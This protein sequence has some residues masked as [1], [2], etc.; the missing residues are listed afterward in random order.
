MAD[1]NLMEKITHA[2]KFRVFAWSNLL[3][4]VIVY[5]ESGSGSHEGR[6]CSKTFE[7]DAPAA[8]R[9]SCSASF[10]QKNR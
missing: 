10:V 7:P 6:A 9:A 2:D 8:R 1:L 5:T 4:M 3:L